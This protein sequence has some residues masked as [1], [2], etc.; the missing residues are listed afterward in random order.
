M[1][2]PFS[3]SSSVF[4][5]A[6]KGTQAGEPDALD[7]KVAHSVCWRNIAVTAVILTKFW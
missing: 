5:V 4:T 6:L 7:V 2:N 1:G 3:E